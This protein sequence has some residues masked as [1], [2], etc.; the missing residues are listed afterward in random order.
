[1]KAIVLAGDK[2]YLTPMLTTIKSILYYNQQVK[3]YILHQNIPSDWFHELKIQV[4]KLGSVVEGIYIGDTIDVEWKTQEHISPIAYARYLIPRLIKEERVIYLDSDIIVNGDLSSLFE[5]DFGDY[6]IAAVRDADGNGFNSGVLVIDSQKWRE[7]DVTSI[8][9][10]KTVEYM[11]YLDHTDTD[12]FNGDQTIFNLVFQNHWLELDKRFNLQVGH[13]VIAFYSHWDSHFELDEEPLIIHYTTYRKPWTTLMGYRYRD[14]WWS[15]HD[16]TFDQIS[17]HY[18]G[19]FAVKRVYDFHDINLFTFTDSQDFLYIEELAQTLPNIGFHIGAYTDMG[20]ILLALDKYP[21]VYLYPSMIGA[22]IDEMIE[23]SDAY[24]DIH[25]GSPMNFIVNRYT[26]A[27][28]PVLTFD[29][30]NKNQLEQIVISSQSPQPM[31]EAIKEL[32]KDKMDMKAIVLGANYQYADKVLTT[33]KSICC[34]NRGLRFYLINSDFPTEWF[35]NLN[36]KLKELDCEIV[37]ARVNSSHISQYKT[38]IHYTTFLRYFISDF[39]EEDKVL[40][41][42]CDLVVTRDLSPLFDVELGDYPLAAVKDLGAQVYFN[43]HGFNAGVLLINNRLWK[44]EEVRKQLIEMTNELH[45]KVA[46]DDQS[47]LNLLFKDRWLVLDFKYNCITLHTHFS[48]YRPE[49]GTYPPIIHYLTERKPWG[50]YERSIYRDVWWYYNAQDWS[51][52]GEATP[53]L[54]KDQVSQYTGVQHSGVQHSAFIYTFSCDLRNIECLIE[55]LPNVKFYIA[56]PV[57]V[58]DSITDLLAYPNVS[59][60]SDIAGQPP[61]IDSLV[62]GC[63]FLLDINADIEVDGIIERF[64]QAGKP[65]FAFESVVHGEQ[66]QFLYDQAHPEEMVLAI[67]AYCQNGELPVKKLKSYPKVLDIQQSLDYILEHHFSVICYGDGE[68]DIMMGH[69]IP[70]QDYDENLAEQLRS[71]IQLESS[72]ELLVCLSDVFEGLERYNPEAVNF[73]QEHLE[74]YKEAYHRFCTASFYGSTFI[75]RPYMDLKDKTA[76]VAHFEKLKQL[77]DERDILI[78]EGENSRSGVGND[79]FDNARSVERIICPSRNAYGKVQ[80]I[81][82]AVEKY[83]DGKL[84]FLM[85]GPTAKVLAYHLSQKGIQAIDLGHVDSEYEWF[86]MGATSKVKFSHKHT[87]EHNFDQEIQFVEDEIYNKQVVVRI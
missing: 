35:Y 4:E 23:K 38:N 79:L 49:S 16:V 56:A 17:D 21:N 46:Q 50:L 69:G 40:Y 74:H 61:L 45:D 54:T 11:S 9:F 31:I 5:L 44:Q 41:L 18:Q 7:K 24:L 51:D 75:S 13:D 76:S 19:R 64:R 42:D 39:V 66:G 27:D 3:I 52:I 82:E 57:M 84:V 12:R 70:Y 65:V 43:E 58:A 63:D 28:R 87:A 15:F 72:P 80:V 29:V 68:M 81:Q 34:H 6:S 53:C 78:V 2:N 67:E 48:D 1:M 86:K 85:L 30:T 26:S 14:L 71:M 59:V 73:W 33:I 36:R 77:W 47:I 20:D 22:V 32:K 60:L 83:A 62:E 55:G 37:N 25:K 8:L 10:D